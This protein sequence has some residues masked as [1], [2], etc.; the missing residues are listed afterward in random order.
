MPQKTNRLNFSRGEQVRVNVRCSV[1]ASKIRKEK[2]DGRD[3]IVVPSYTLPDDIVM[4]GVKYPAEEIE[5]GYKT[6]ENSPA[7]L[8][9]PMVNDMF[10]S[11][12]SPLGL[13]L[14]YFGA[15]NANVQRKDGRVYLE[16][17][18]DVQRASESEMGRRVLEALEEG[19]PIH[20]STGVLL[21]LRGCSDTDTAEYEG[22]NMEFD[23]DAILL[24]ERGA[25]TPEQGVGML[26]NKATNKD[27]HEI[28][29]INSDMDRFDDMIDY[30]GMELLS[31]IDRKETASRWDRIKS[32]IME[33]LS[34]SREPQSQT[35]EE[36]D[37][38]DN[39]T[40]GF[41]EIA[42]RVDQMEKAIN[43]MAE[44]VEKLSNSFDGAAASIEALNAD[45]KA[46]RDALVNRVVK[47][48]L[49]SE[50]EA[51]STPDTVLGKL[52]GNSEVKPAPGIAGGY[53][54]NSGDFSLASDWEN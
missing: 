38:A 30:Y 20:T 42:A 26:V 11:A 4:N 40:E 52:L 39:K 13:N 10:V 44:T 21:N 31:A 3:V 8:G 54:T 33:A 14:G 29:A 22:Y 32:A 16:K 46:K 50:E 17:M 9:H 47:A 24:D 41:E 51:K 34:P 1:N 19:K 2:R 53:K 27:G 37:M 43:T 23:H 49:L 48:E 15:W 45:R 36:D 35:M 18:I 5:K 7:P 6:L 28:A 25:A 12:R